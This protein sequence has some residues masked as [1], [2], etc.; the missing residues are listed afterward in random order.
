[1]GSRRSKHNKGRKVDKHHALFGV[2]C[3]KCFEQSLIPENK[4]RSGRPYICSTCSAHT[5]NEKALRTG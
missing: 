5:E 3:E 2:I 1:M 4:I